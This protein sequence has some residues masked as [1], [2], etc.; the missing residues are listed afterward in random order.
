MT[1]FTDL[2][3]K[4]TAAQSAALGLSPSQA[5]IVQPATPAPMDDDDALWA[6]FNAIPA[7]GPILTPSGTR[8]FTAY[9]TVIRS[10]TPGS[11]PLDPIAAAQR[12][13]ADW[14][15][16]P[17]TWSLGG[18]NLKKLLGVAPSVSFPF[19]SPATPP[20]GLW[21]LWGGSVPCAGLSAEF[22]AG[23]V[24]GTVSFTRCLNFA[25]TPGD[26]YVGSA[27]GLAYASPNQSPWTP[28]SPI[29]W[30]S[31]FGPSGT[32]TRFTSALVVVSGI[33]IGYSS[34]TVF[35][36]TE[37]A[38]IRAQ[39]ASGLWPYYQ[40]KQ[41]SVSFDPEG[42]LTVSVTTPTTQPLVIAASAISAAAYLGA[43]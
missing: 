18:A 40:P 23:T 1:S 16:R 5:R 42:R 14:G 9:G 27:L 2:Q 7:D 28:G 11:N 17:P 35:S 39:A 24:T 19:S 30:Q 10:L 26:W 38:A 34:T 33:Q 32:L 25:P 29:T 12:R 22:A 41:Q 31:T 6:P 15:D 21:G 37:R 13:L 3:E 8:F 20:T 4:F 43:E 36:A